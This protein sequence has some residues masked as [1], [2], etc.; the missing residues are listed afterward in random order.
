[1][2]SRLLTAFDTP[3]R[4]AYGYNAR[5]EVASARRYNGATKVRGF[6]HDYAYD[7]IGNRTSSTEYD[8]EDNALVS[9]YAANALNQ[10]EQR[11]V[12]GYAGVR[13]SATNNATVTVN[14][15]SAWRLGKYFYGGDDADNAASAVMKELAVTAVVNP[16]GTNEADLVESVTGRVFVAKSPETFTY[17]D[18]G[19]MLSDGR[20]NYTWDG[21]NRLASIEASA[22]AASAGAS[23]VKVEYSYDHRS[24]RIGK[25]ISRGGA[26]AQSWEVAESRSFVYDGWNMIQ[27]LTHTQTHTLTNFYTWGLDLSGSLQG[28][29]GVGGLLADISPLPLGEGQGEGSTAYLPCYDGNGNV[30]EYLSTDGTLAAH[31][32]YSPFGETVIQ[33]GE[34]ADAFAFRFSTKYWENEA[35]LYYYGY[36]FYAPA[37]G[38][39]LNRDPIGESLQ[40]NVYSFINNKGIQFIDYMGLLTIYIGGAA[41][42]TLGQLN[43][44]K[45]AAGCSESFDN[46]QHSEI[47]SRINEIH[48]QN[49]CEPIILVG[50]SYGGDTAMDVA[51][52][53]KDQ[54]CLCLYVIT[55]DPV[56]HFDPDTW[57]W[58]NP[59]GTNIVEW[60]NVFQSAGLSD[61]VAAIPV[62]GWVFGGVW[63]LGG[64]ISGNNDMVAS[65]GG[66]WNEMSG[67]DY[68]IDMGNIDHQDILNIMKLEFTD[69]SGRKI[70]LQDYIKELDGGNCCE[71]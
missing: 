7:P 11:T 60:I 2:E 6:S 10:Y 22:A 40:R 49:P 33:S 58:Q 35:K 16:A 20:F 8:H 5:S 65:G 54:K 37:T 45:K 29:G 34:M 39:W 23:R 12:P 47:V 53:L 42:R 71:K 18:D 68:S 41:E 4:D 28:A 69:S 3:V 46:K 56:S 38:R 32:E 57:L 62:V 55:L 30:M 43:D 13:G 67:A 51:A 36:R 17:D 50:H 1:M 44:N 24:R 27:E 9:S 14:G 31:Y 63:A 21:E 26:E 19:N 64:V 25:V 48:K 70:S 52:M 15:T 61:Y 59:A 66:Q